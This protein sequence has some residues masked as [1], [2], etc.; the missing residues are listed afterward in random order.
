MKKQTIIAV[1]LFGMA[2]GQVPAELLVGTTTNTTIT[3]P[4]AIGDF[5]LG[6]DYP[7]LQ[8]RSFSTG[9][10]CSLTGLFFGANLYHESG[11]GGISFS[12][13][14][15]STSQPGSLVA[16]GLNLF[17]ATSATIGNVLAPG[18]SL[19]LDANTAY[20]LVA[21]VDQTLGSTTYKWNQT[22]SAAFESDFAGTGMPLAYANGTD[23]TSWA[24]YSGSSMAMEIHAVP[25]PGTI[26]L[27]GLGFFGSLLAR[28]RRTRKSRSREFE[29]PEYTRPFL[30]EET[31]RPLDQ[32]ALY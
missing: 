6:A 3:A 9:A 11:L 7:I 1:A 13:Y 16:G 27:M 26:S 31:E 23:G 28:R 20:W 17:S 10:A 8:A 29:L 32:S 5:G 25:E 15:D 12:I 14:T 19:A 21:S 18:A 30:E 4:V 22:D 2:A 24:N